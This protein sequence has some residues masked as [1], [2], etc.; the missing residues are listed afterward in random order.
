MTGLRVL[1]VITGLATG[2]AE[3]QLRELL[4]HTRHD[5]EV[6]VLTNPGVLADEIAAA[7]VV[8]HRLQMRSNTDVAVIPR[9]AALIRR[10]RY[11][12]VQTH[13]Y[14]A[15][16]YGRLAARMAG[17]RAVLATEHSLTP[18]SIEG[19][20]TDRPGVR[21]MY[22]AAERLGRM[23]VAVSPTVTRLLAQ[24]GV[25]DARVRM[26]PNGIDAPAF[27]F[28]PAERQRVRTQL[29]I[30]TDAEVIGSVSRLVPARRVELLIDAA[31]GLS[32]TVLLLVGD[33]AAMSE[34]RE[35]A[36]RHGIA[37]RVIFTGESR[38]VPAMYAAMDVYVATSP[39]E[40][41]GIAVLEALAAGLPTVYVTCPAIDDLPADRFPRARRCAADPAQLRRAVRAALGAPRERT[42]AVAVEYA[43]PG[44]ARQVDDLYESLGPRRTPG[45]PVPVPR[46]GHRVAPAGL[47]PDP[48]HV[49]HLA[50]PTDGGVRR[51]VV[52][53]CADQLGRGWRVS[54]ACPDGP[55]AEDV[56]A[57]GVDWRSWEATRA[58]GPATLRE[59]WAASRIVAD[60]QPDVVHL[61]SSKAGLAGRFAVAGR[62]PT[63]F[64]P[65][66]W[67]WL[68]TRG[69]TR[70]LAL[71]WE[72]LATRLAD[73]VVC[74]GD[75]EAAVGRAEGLTGPLRVVRNGVD[76]ARFSPADARSARQARTAL[77]LP[78]DGPIVLCPG[79]LSR[80]KGQDVLLAAW[81]GVLAR[82]PGATLVLLGDGEMTAELRTVATPG[83]RFVPAATDL[84]PWFAA[85]DV[86]AM[87]SRWEGLPLVALEAAAS[88]RAVVGSAIPGLTEV[89]TPETGE[90][91]PPE[92]PAALTEALAGLLN[93][94][95]L[96]HRRGAAARAVATARFDHR[97][98]YERL[99]ELTRSIAG[100]NPVP[101]AP[102][103]PTELPTT[104][105]PGTHPAHARALG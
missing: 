25:P 23:T 104:G 5:A 105:V 54:V 32:G 55:L 16:L 21:T 22:L 74:V 61:H 85:A 92:D 7:G 51:Y 69:R 45:G 41:F 93:D 49:L 103:A 82:S 57:L 8:V 87:P 77:D 63:I 33:G 59:T 12:V 9:L 75:G 101:A 78:A 48:P 64:Q 17:V 28:D 73:A 38:D 100:L 53:A 31:A 30:P 40:T 46:R 26:I 81:P 84:R 35:R 14:R 102:P 86:V 67:S 19:R 20:P 43:L 34:L 80:Q 18:T 2:G 4:R 42:P 24:W 72:R 91:V 39:Y 71:G 3:Q 62:R 6:A 99:A 58:P 37:D 94:P 36:H 27:R 95:D 52:E 56:R 90:L 79:R 66:G 97:F 29:G 70:A 65:H 89:V 60:S 96:A 13:L 68:A 98:T 83:V 47:P 44:I 15:M 76:C 11:D 50:Q 10:G 88:G 1:H